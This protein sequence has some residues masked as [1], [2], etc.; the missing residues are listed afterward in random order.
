MANLFQAFLDSEAFTMIF[1]V[2]LAV[3][4]ASELLLIGA[5]LMREWL[6]GE[7]ERELRYVKSCVKSSTAHIEIIDETNKEV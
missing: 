2:L 3:S 5:L 7:F 4:G 6:E 1:W